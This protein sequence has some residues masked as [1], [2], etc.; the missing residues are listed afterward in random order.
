LIRLTALDGIDGPARRVAHYR[1]RIFQGS[2]QR[3]QGFR[4]AG[5]AQYQSGITE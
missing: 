5:I 3:R 1:L 4:A 2:A